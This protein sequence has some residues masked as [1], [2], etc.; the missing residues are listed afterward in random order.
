MKKLLAV[1]SLL[2]FA[3][4]ILGFAAGPVNAPA[5]S[6]AGSG[7]S[8]Q[9][10]GNPLPLP[11]PHAAPDPSDALIADGNP[12]PLPVPHAADSWRG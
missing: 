5:T 7:Y 1:C 4:F 10:D 12:L 6:P 3:A 9:A 2:V 11:V 8:I